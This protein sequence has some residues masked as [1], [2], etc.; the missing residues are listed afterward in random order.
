MTH[1]FSRLSNTFLLRPYC[2]HAVVAHTCNP[3]SW[4]MEAEDRQIQAHI[5]ATKLRPCLKK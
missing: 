2:L 3:N 1:S 4:E 5:G